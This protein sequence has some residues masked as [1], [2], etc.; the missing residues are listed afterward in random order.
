MP[1]FLKFQIEFNFTNITNEPI[2]KYV[3]MFFS[4]T[5]PFKHIS[6][7]ISLLKIFAFEKNENGGTY[8]QGNRVS[9][10]LPLVV[11]KYYTNTYVLSVFDNGSNVW[12]FQ[13]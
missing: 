7:P 3:K 8:M 2:K 5:N 13:V 1:P 10:Y 9:K 11:R 12:H 6:I 4:Y